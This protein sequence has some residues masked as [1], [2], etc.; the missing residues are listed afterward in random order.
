MRNRK[1]FFRLCAVASLVA[2]LTGC[3]LTQ[4]V[5]QGSSS[6]AKAIFVKKVDPFHLRLTARSALNAD[7]GQMS[8]TVEV[9]VWSLRNTAAFTQAS[10]QT[11]LNKAPE[12]L[13][14]DLT[15]K[16][17]VIRVTPG[18]SVDRDIPLSDDTQAVAIVGFFLSPDIRKNDWR[19]VI[20][21]DEMDADDPSVVELRE[22]QLLLRHK[23]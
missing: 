19:I 15:G 6:L 3:G 22:N 12:T 5:G 17:V 10:Y 9:R 18:N 16:P 20:A 7:E 21:R 11:L 2:M 8:S 4:K 13:A 1:L 23:D 14:N